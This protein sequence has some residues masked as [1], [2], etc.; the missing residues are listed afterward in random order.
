MK[1]DITFT[2]SS[3]KV[4][5]DSQVIGLL[6]AIN[7]EGSITQAAKSV[8]L[9]YKRAWD[10]LDILNSSLECPAIS[11]EIGGP[12]GGG[13]VLTNNGGVIMQTYFKMLGDCKK[14]AMT[15]KN[16]EAISSLIK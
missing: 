16:D 3:G 12:G 9:S 8:G 7:S 5:I 13:T 2:N 15:A 14:A 10:L 11:T 4:V 6:A 1:I